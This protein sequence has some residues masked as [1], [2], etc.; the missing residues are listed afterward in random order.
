LGEP[1]THEHYCNKRP[2]T[3]TN[4]TTAHSRTITPLQRPVVQMTMES[5]QSSSDAAFE[6]LSFLQGELDAK[7]DEINHMHSEIKGAHKITH[8]RV[9]HTYTHT[10]THTHTR[11]SPDTFHQPLLLHLPSPYTH[12]YL[13]THRTSLVLCRFLASID[14]T[15]R[16]APCTLVR[17][18]H[19]RAERGDHGAEAGRWWRSDG[20]TLAAPVQPRERFACADPSQQAHRGA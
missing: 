13:A 17:R 6:K 20:G 15:S 11:L 12:A 7:Q 3:I 10:H 16:L 4:A 5:G 8:T 1:L 2:C 14:L 9:T 18:A 19:R